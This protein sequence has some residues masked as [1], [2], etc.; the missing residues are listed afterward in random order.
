MKFITFNY[1]PNDTVSKK[2]LL[3]LILWLST[4]CLSGQDRKAHWIDSVFQTL[5]LEE[6]VGQLFVLRASSYD[7]KNDIADLIEE[8]KDH[9]P[10]GIVITGGGPVG[11]ANLINAVQANS[12][13]PVLVLMAAGTGP[14]AVLD[15][16]VSYPSLLQLG[17][18]SDDTLIYEFGNEVARQLKLLGVHLNLAPEADIDISPVDP[19]PYWG[20][21]KYRVAGQSTSFAKGLQTKNILACA[22]HHTPEE[23]V[24]HSSKLSNGLDLSTSVTDTVSFY[25]FLELMKNK[26]DGISTTNLHFTVLDKKKPVPPS[27]SRLFMNDI[28]KRK[29]G[30]RG[31]TV[32]EVPYFHRL[33]GKSRSD[34][35][36]IAFEVGHDLILYPHNLNAAIK[37]IISSVKKNDA[38]SQQLETSVRK[39]LAAK[40]DAGLNKYSPCNSNGLINRLNSSEAKLMQFR[41]AEASL[42]LANNSKEV[43][44]IQHLDDKKIGL[45]SIG[46][47]GDGEF[48][49]YLKKYAAIESIPVPQLS[50]TLGLNARLAPFD[51]VIISLHQIANADLIG[52]MSWVNS[53]KNR[54]G[55]M[56][57]DFGNPFR[58]KNLDEFPT[59]LVGYTNSS[60]TPMIAA[61][62]I[63]GARQAKGTLPISVNNYLKEGKG[64]ISPSLDRLAYGIPAQAGMSEKVLE[65]IDD[66]VQQAID[67][68]ATPGCNVLIAKDG[69]VVYHRAIG[70]KT[71]EKNDP[72]DQET[73][74]DLASITK[75]AATLQAVMFM[76]D[77]K[78]IDLNKKV[79][80]YLPELKG[81][82]KQ[83]F[84]I[85]DILTH[86]A[87]LWPYL[88][89]WQQTI[90]DSVL[91]DDYY[92][93]NQTDEFP[94]TVSK[95]VFARKT[96]KDSLWRWIIDARIKEKKPK[97]PYE[98]TYS[99]MGFYIMQH[100][101]EK[102]LNQ[103]IEDF[104]MQNFYEPLGAK[105]T[106]FLPLQR[107]SENQIAPTED[108]HQF[109]QSTLI[110]YVHDQG[111]AMHGGIAG[112]AG[113][114]SSANDLAKLGQ[115]WLQRGHYGGLSFFKPETVDLFTSKQYQTSR[116]GLGWDKPSV[117]DWNGPTSLYASPKTF[118][119]TGFTGTAIWVDPEFNLVY[120]FL[121]NR[122]YPDMF[123]TRLLTGNI[124]PRIQDVIY[125]SI[126]EFCK[127]GK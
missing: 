10:G 75:V 92:S 18:I 90:E 127:G 34:A 57:C 124:R 29:I 121:S 102:L 22:T 44:P 115:M 46:K 52:L 104:L 1:K 84:T 2:V 98:Y 79:S 3:I 87:G 96:M 51:I 54:K 83:D 6:K 43:I 35:E 5:G 74:Y 88:P 65:K 105:T 126:F 89:F 80:V 12:K 15:S 117:S 33:S 58:L 27:L 23:N 47:K 59:V 28:I 53:Q 86:Q 64:F 25:P 119:H 70:W 50:D 108:D 109:R 24:D 114:F 107:F 63:F 118:G 99:D 32:T 7:S 45:V 48:E 81:S 95:N 9:H 20:S 40:Y 49:K 116:R 31:L 8:I 101:A 106:G 85:K 66:I 69:Q 26:V 11:A 55:V 62:V 94:F 56:L 125:E 67:S 78:L 112:H 93:P 42:T 71:Y 60:P 39:I 38:F 103:P 76:Q 123:N 36:R 100:L 111:A 13:V 14:G 72:L 73:I 110:G 4:Y 122:V 41:L 91:L 17:A 19:F 97:V 37:R 61:Q 77:R 68:G 113:L 120:V 21:N 82:N 30:F 16:L